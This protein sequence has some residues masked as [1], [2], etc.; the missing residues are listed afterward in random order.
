[1]TEISS[2]RLRGL[3][4]ADV[5]EEFWAE[6]G[7]Q[8]TPLVEEVEEAGSRLVTFV[9]RGGPDTRQVA[10]VAGPAGFALPQNQMERLGESDLW[11]RSYRV[12]ADAR[13]FYQLAENGPQLAPW[14][15][16]DF[17]A[18]HESWRADPLNPRTYAIVE[19]EGSEQV[20][21]VL[22][23]ADAPAMPF[24]RFDPVVPRGRLSA[25]ALESVVMKETRPLLEYTSDP[26]FGA[27]S[28][29]LIVFDGVAFTR[30]VP[31]PTI[32][33]NLIAAGRIPPTLAVFVDS[34]GDRRDRDLPCNDLFT[35]FLACELVPWIEQRYGAFHAQR[36]VLAGASYGGVCSAYAGLRHPEHFGNVLSMSGSH[37]VKV[38]GS[39]EWA[40]LPRLFEACERLPLR[41]YQCVGSFEAGN[42]V[43]DA[44]PCQITANRRMHEVLRAKGYPV[45]YTEYSGG[46]DW[47][48]WEHALAEGLI[49]LVGHG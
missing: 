1:M 38:K 34:L 32:L 16:R 3:R 13:C 5:G 41:F 40:A 47:I 24:S 21:S 10:V 39:P 44:A 17:A 22:E 2:A 8:G 4:S 25:H 27:P 26:S 36:T 15:T 28:V 18:L 49:E 14:Q 30:T 45:R 37:W 29:L 6:I 23:L 33:D 12:A 46:H 7:R 31:T 9:L 19:Q 48:C 11:F 42:R 20:V 35:T 43:V